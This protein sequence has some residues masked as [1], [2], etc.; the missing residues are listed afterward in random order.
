MS[1][2][3]KNWFSNYIEFDEP[4]EYQGLLFRTPEN[5]FQAMKA[6]KYLIGIRRKISLMSPGQAKKFWR[7]SYN[8]K[9][10]MREDWFSISLDVMVHVI[11][12]KFKPGTTHYNNLMNTD[13]VIVEVNNWHD[14]F[15]G[16][17]ICPK[18]KKKEKYNH[19][20]KILTNLRNKYNEENICQRKVS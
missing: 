8:K 7:N 11:S 4:Y 2:W 1:K 17:C 5:F 16:E 3:I 20:G 9:R 15:W 14:N 10:Y 18:C 12:V 19:L 13:G 6:K